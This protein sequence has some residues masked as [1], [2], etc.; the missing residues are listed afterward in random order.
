MIMGEKHQS[1]SVTFSWQNRQNGFPCMMRAHTIFMTQR[2]RVSSAA[3]ER[4]HASLCCF[5]YSSASSQPESSRARAA[6]ARNNETD[7]T[8]WLQ[9]S[10]HE[11]FMPEYDRRVFEECASAKRADVGFANLLGGY[12]RGTPTLKIS[13]QL[14]YF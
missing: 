10:G 12:K 1:Q 11:I 13:S 6:D 5:A 7:G 2:A 8:R 9:I 14:P 4:F 3:R